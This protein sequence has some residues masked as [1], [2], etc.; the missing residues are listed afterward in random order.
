MSRQIKDDI[1]CVPHLHAIYLWVI[2]H[3]RTLPPINL[4]IFKI[5]E[6]ERNPFSR[7]TFDLFLPR[8]FRVPVNEPSLPA[9]L[10]KRSLGHETDQN[11]ITRKCDVPQNS[12]S[13]CLLQHIWQIWVAGLVSDFAVRSPVSGLGPQ[14]A[15]GRLIERG[16][17]FGI[18]FP[19]NFNIFSR[20]L[21]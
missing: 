19:D 17:S 3:F 15:M 9:W 20:V 4:G 8:F 1:D 11:V 14:G 2:L 21:L 6:V 7:T 16:N 5:Q 12:V 10:G 13:L 18:N